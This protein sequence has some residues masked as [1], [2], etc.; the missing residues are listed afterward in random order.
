MYPLAVE[1][2]IPATEYW[3]M[4]FEEI[5]VQVQANKKVRERDMRDKA[6]MD[7]KLAQLN[8]YSFNDPKKMPKLDEFYGLEN[9]QVNESLDGSEKPQSELSAEERK[10]LKQKADMMQVAAAIKRTNARKREGG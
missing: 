9:D 6:I 2:G 3:A 10:W 1:S 8:A 4:T 5:M 7:Y